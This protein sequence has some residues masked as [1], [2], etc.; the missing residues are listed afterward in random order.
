MPRLIFVCG[1]IGAGKTTYSISL[2]D[3]TKAVRFSI[4]SWMQNLFSKDLIELDFLWITERVNR[5]NLQIRDIAA[6]VL[7]SDSSVIL[8]LGFTTKDQRRVFHRWA[9]DMNI[10]P[11]LHYLKASRKLRKLRVAKRNREKDPNLYAFEM[12]DTIFNFMEPKF[13]VPDTK[14]LSNSIII[15][16]EST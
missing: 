1:A 5:C 11:E 13:E 3:E 9:E 16:A 2:A 10:T 8:D 12:T 4:D 7:K 6:Q 15:D 14:E